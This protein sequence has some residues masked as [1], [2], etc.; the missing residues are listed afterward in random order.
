MKLCYTV[1]FNVYKEMEDSMS[2]KG[3]SYRIEYAV[4]AMKLQC[5]AYYAEFKWLHENYIPTFEEYMSAALVSST[6]QLISIVSFVSME[7]CITKETFIWAFNDP[8][9]LRA[10]TFIGRL[11]NDVVSHQD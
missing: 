2:E 5:Q 11:I 7:D 3:K 4:E 1:V 10:S 6:Y 9:F 8:K